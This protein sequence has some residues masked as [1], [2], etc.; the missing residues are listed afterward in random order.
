MNS[1]LLV[2]VIGVGVA[3]AENCI[4]PSDCSMERC[5]TGYDV[6]CEENICSCGQSVTGECSS[7]T[8][9]SALY[10]LC[11][12]NDKHWYCNGHQCCCGEPCPHAGDSFICHSPSDCAT[13]FFR[14]ENNDKHWYCTQNHCHCGSRYGDIN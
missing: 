14:C 12:N 10:G 6:T 5:P 1:I 4:T 9:C 7:S 8:D 3:V 11:D 13:E 2:F